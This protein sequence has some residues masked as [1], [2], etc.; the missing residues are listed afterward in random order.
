MESRLDIATAPESQT[1]LYDTI[2]DVCNVAMPVGEFPAR[3]T[4]ASQNDFVARSADGEPGVG[5]DDHPLWSK[6]PHQYDVR[7]RKTANFG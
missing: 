4:A 3:S 7:L 5:G 1:R 2:I 6:T